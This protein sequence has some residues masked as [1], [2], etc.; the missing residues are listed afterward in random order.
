MLKRENTF[1]VCIEKDLLLEDYTRNP[2]TGLKLHDC[3]LKWSD[4]C[5]HCEYG[6]DDLKKKLRSP[7]KISEETFS[8][9]ES[10]IRDCDFKLK[11]FI[12]DNV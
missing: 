6:F 7:G 8:E 3:S 4:S 9:I 1:N 5:A 2:V 12:F 10:K 11:G